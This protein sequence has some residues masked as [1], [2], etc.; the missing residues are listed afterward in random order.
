MH[1]RP[2]LTIANGGRTWVS[3][4]QS[5]ALLSAD[6]RSLNGEDSW[7]IEV[8]LAL[9]C[10]MSRRIGL[11]SSSEKWVNGS[12]PGCGLIIRPLPH[13]YICFIYG[14]RSHAN[15]DRGRAIIVKWSQVQKKPLIS[16]CCWYMACGSGWALSV[17]KTGTSPCPLLVSASTTLKMLE[18]VF[19]ESVIFCRST[20]LRNSRSCGREVRRIVRIEYSTAVTEVLQS[21][22]PLAYATFWT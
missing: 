1:R 2:W 8:E 21:A 17:R 6:S 16:A 18:V 19:F 11:Y 14:W 9:G 22:I 3:N 10:A 12:W 7:M 4:F 15:N 13:L 20:R 5:T